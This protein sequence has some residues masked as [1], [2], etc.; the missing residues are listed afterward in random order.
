MIIPSI[1]DVDLAG[2]RVFIRVDF[3]VPLGD[4]GIIT[5]DSRIRA[6]LPTIKLAR[7]AGAKVIL[8]SHLGRPDGKRVPA[9]TLRPAG[10]RLAELTG[11]EIIFPDDCIGDGPRYLVNNLREGQIL[12]LENLRF[13]P[14]EEANDEMFA[15]QLAAFADVYVNDAFGAAHRAHASIVGMTHHVTE[16]VAGLLL[17]R[18]ITALQRLVERPD[19]PF[20]AVIGGA[21]VKDK[22]GV[23][24]ALLPKVDALLVGG[25]MAATFLKARG[26]EMGASRIEPERVA[27][28]E[29][30]LERAEQLDVDLLLPIDHVIVDRKEDL[31]PAP[32]TRVVRNG[33]L[34]DTALACDIGPQTVSAFESIIATARTVFWN[35]PMGIF[36]QAPFARGTEAVAKA[37]AHSGGFTVV[38]GGDTVAAVAKAGVT[39]FIG[40]VSTGGS[41]SLEFIEGRR[42]P[43]LE[44]LRAGEV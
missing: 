38:G 37:A 8:A 7:E 3:N 41:A 42:L 40:H 6:A 29:R 11:Q 44:A 27:A 16:K 32:R 22:I 39:P 30:T 13:H 34:S 2:K 25:A 31:G 12:L 10:D 21:R 20:V 4:G 5:D 33:E 23:I 35:G 18:E 24:Q 26:W 1:R 28:A 19:K 15:R 9:C 14:E 36:E 17:T 43:G